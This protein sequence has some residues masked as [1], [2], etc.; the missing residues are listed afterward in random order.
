[1]TR[2][3]SFNKD[4]ALFAGGMFLILSGLAILLSLLLHWLGVR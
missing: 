2:K 1:M 4:D 3:Q